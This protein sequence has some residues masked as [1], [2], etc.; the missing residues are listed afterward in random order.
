MNILFNFSFFC[1]GC[2][3]DFA[4][5]THAD[6]EKKVLHPGV[7]VD[8]FLAHGRRLPRRLRH[9]AP[10]TNHAHPRHSH[11]LR[12]SRLLLQLQIARCNRA[13]PHRPTA[14]DRFQLLQHLV[15]L[16]AILS[17]PDRPQR[18]LISFRFSTL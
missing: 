10:R 17:H 2:T 8:S 7:F 14:L 1:S 18:N 3:C 15:Q 16:P 5:A 6:A 9:P 11:A 12:C 4:Q 13:D